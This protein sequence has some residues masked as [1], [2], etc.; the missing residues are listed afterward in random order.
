MQSTFGSMSW[1]Q[2]VFFM[3]VH[4][5]LWTVLI[6]EGERQSVLRTTKVRTALKGDNSWI[7]RREQENLEKD[8]EEKPWWEIYIITNLKVQSSQYNLSN[9]FSLVGSPKWEQ[10]VQMVCLK[11]QVLFPH[12]QPMCLSPYPTQRSMHYY[13][14]WSTSTFTHLAGQINLKM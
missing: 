8:E 9:A 11:K 10:T 14:P 7:Q 6:S 3:L 1:Y 13:S 5:K 4:D 12:P 2:N